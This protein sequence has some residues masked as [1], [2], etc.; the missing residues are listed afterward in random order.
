MG[1]LQ[2]ETSSCSPY[3]EGDYT[4]TDEVEVHHGHHRA[5]QRSAAGLWST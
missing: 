3:A 5:T 4:V 1:L 2:E